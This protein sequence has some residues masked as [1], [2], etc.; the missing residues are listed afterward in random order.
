[1]KEQRKYRRTGQRGR[2]IR[3]VLRFRIEGEIDP[4]AEL[5]ASLVDVSAGG[6]GLCT[7]IRL[8]LG[9]ILRFSNTR[10]HPELQEQG[11]VI[12]TAESQEGVQVGVKFV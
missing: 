2:S 9:Q 5:T 11:Q 7:D 6:A 10:K 4:G 3:S 8:E 1:M 12:W